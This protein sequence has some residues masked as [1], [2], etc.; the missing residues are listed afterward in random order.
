MHTHILFRG[1]NIGKSYITCNKLL[2]PIFHT[3]KVP[4]SRFH[5]SRSPFHKCIEV[6]KNGVIDLPSKSITIHCPQISFISL[7]KGIIIHS[8]S[9]GTCMDTLRLVLCLTGNRIKVMKMEYTWRQTI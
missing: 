8:G 1:L 9:M 5:C 2:Y 6:W 7:V 4:C 3:R